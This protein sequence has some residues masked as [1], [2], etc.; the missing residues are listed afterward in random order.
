VESATG[1]FSQEVTTE[2]GEKKILPVVLSIGAA[3]L[4][5]ATGVTG[6]NVGL[7]TTEFHKP[8]WVQV[9]LGKVLMRLAI[10]PSPRGVS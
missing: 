4:A 5:N 3:S 8:S 2:K 7:E 9:S 10:S 1:Q 6:G